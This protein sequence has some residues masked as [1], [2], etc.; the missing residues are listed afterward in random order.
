MHS[1]VFSTVAGLVESTAFTRS[2]KDHNIPEPVDI[3]SL[4][5]C[6]CGSFCPS[7]TSIEFQYKYV[8]MGLV[9]MSWFEGFKHISRILFRVMHCVSFARR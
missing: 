7:T 4:A 2:T 9:L 1:L 5:G 8:S 3:L 6:A